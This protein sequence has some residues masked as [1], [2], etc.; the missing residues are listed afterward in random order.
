MINPLIAALGLELDLSAEEIAD[1]IWLA[2]QMQQSVPLRARDD[3]P[4]EAAPQ[5]STPAREKPFVPPKPRSQQ[6]PQEPQGEIVPQGSRS[7]ARSQELA[8]QVPDVRS[9][10]QPL[11]LAR[12][13]R[14]LLRRI[15]TGNSTVLNEAATIQ[16]IVEEQLWIPVL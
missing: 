16:R 11:D 7:P 4:A 14:P 12:S 5:T 9:L 13:L 1:V 10:R 3:M 8:F 2:T 15:A 6:K